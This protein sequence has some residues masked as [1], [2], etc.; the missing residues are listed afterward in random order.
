MKTELTTTLLTRFDR[1]AG[2]RSTWETHWQEV[3]DFM[4]PRK[5][6][7]VRRRSRGANMINATFFS[8]TSIR[9]I[10]SITTWYDD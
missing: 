2:R 5:A 9:I 4:L 3:A 7:I 1:L 8:I 6:D 10:S